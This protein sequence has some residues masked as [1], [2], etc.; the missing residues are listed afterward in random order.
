MGAY[1][2]ECVW[3]DAEGIAPLSQEEGVRRGGVC[4]WNKKLKTNWTLLEISCLL[5]FGPELTYEGNLKGPM[6]A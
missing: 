5:T 3:G 6:L 2:G 1:A 4:K